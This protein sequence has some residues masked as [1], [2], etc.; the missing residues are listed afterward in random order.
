MFAHNLDLALP[1]KCS[2]SIIQCL[3]LEL[4]NKEV[5]VLFCSI[6]R[7]KLY[8]L[9][10]SHPFYGIYMMEPSPDYKPISLLASL[11][12]DAFIK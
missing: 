11:L 12:F 1:D 3:E 4:L 7:I 6:I 8:P 9:K 5:E 10:S 2:E